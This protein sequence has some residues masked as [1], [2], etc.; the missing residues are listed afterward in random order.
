LKTRPIYREANNGVLLLCF[1]AF[2]AV[3]GQGSFSAAQAPQPQTPATILPEGL[4]CDHSVSPLGVDAW[5]PAL[6]WTLTETD[7]TARGLQQAAYEVL[8]SGSRSA[9]EH[10]LGDRWDSGKISSPLTASVPY[11]G[12]ALSSDTVYLWKVRVWDSGGR[13]SAWSAPATFLTGLLQPSDWTAKWIAAKA[14]E[15]PALQPRGDQ[16]M[17]VDSVPALPLFRDRFT[18]AATKI[19]RATLFISGMGES[20]TLINGNAITKALLTPGWTDYRKTV[21]YDSYDVT[22]LLHPGSNVLA[23]LLGNGMYNVE[24]VKGRYTKFVGSFV[25]PKVIA[26]LRIHFADGTVTTVAT[27]PQWR[28]IPGPI[29]FSSIYGGEDF[30][31][32]RLPAGWTEAAFDDAAWNSP[33]TVQGP[34]GRLLSERIPPVE[35]IE[36]YT[37]IRITHPTPSTTVYDLGQNFAGVAK[38]TVSGPAGSAVHV[39]PGELLNSAGRV[40]QASGNAFPDDPVL[41]DYT[42]SGSGPQFWS[43]LFS[44]Y[45]FRYAEVT[46]NSPTAR[47]P[48]LSGFRG[49]SIHD[50]VHIDGSFS[51]SNPL[52]NRIHRLIDRA[53]EN[54]LFSVLTDCPTREKLG[55]LEQTHLAGTS[56]MY[57]YELALL[58]RKMARDMRDSQ[59]PSGA[60]PSIA[61]EVVA[62]DGSFRD[63]PEWGSAVILSPWTAYTFY[64]DLQLLRDEYPAMVAYANYLQ[65]RTRDNLLSYGLGDWYDIGP[66]APGESKLT[67]KDVTATAIYFQD[68]TDLAQI[69]KLLDQTADAVDFGARAARVKAAFNEKLFHPDTNSYDRGS[70][71]AEAMPLVLGLVPEARRQAVLDNLVKDIRAHNN[72]VT[73]GDIGYHYVVRALTDGGRSGVLYDMLSR[74][75]SPSYGYQLKQG[76]TALTEAW[77]SNPTSSQDHFMLGHAEEWFYRGLGG[78]DFDLSRSTNRRIWIHPQPVGSLGSVHVTY[79]SVLGT[80]ASS[81]RHIGKSLQMDITVPAGATA[82]FTLPAQF[83]H[84][85]RESNHA[86]SQGVGILSIEG[87]NDSVSCIVSSGTYHFFAQQ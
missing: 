10:N 73:A 54:N 66:G 2:Y 72:H 41:F 6:H 27:G 53:M 51:S 78:I 8:V 52:L 16:D 44:Y 15:P 86:L 83:H 63:S 70:Q 84:H 69:A 75:D 1:F 35:P 37:P 74:T 36:T 79:D 81:W 34:G 71:T 25:Q 14:D 85:V 32:R 82:T 62:F 3:L 68:I 45:G 39:L 42:L 80:I 77:D 40:T 7:P 20:H 49:E 38:L 24:G 11:A 48:T 60:V 57:N 17:P 55:W 4:T 30:D 9:L 47:L 65:S 67:S 28:T 43:P 5:A 59:L 33:V 56:L 87:T 76:A 29:V 23:V 18:V 12:Q 19:L 58:Y 22:A 61:P 21:L 50:A 64:G 26:E 31:A 13:P 46:R